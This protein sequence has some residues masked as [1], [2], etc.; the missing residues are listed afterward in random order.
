MKDSAKTIKLAK[1]KLRK[2]EVENRQGYSRD[3]DDN[4]HE[5]PFAFF[6]ENG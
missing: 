1:L 5:D 3:I 6:V 2:N 4:E